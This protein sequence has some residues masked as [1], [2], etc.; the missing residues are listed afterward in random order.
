MSVP[1]GRDLTGTYEWKDFSG[2]T[3]KS[4]IYEIRLDN[5]TAAFQQ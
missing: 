5:Y 4:R 1:T 3:V 2:D